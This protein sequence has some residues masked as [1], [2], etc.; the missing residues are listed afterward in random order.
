[1]AYATLLLLGVLDAAGYSVIAPVVPAIGRANEAGPGVLGP[2]VATF[3]LGMAAGFVVASRYLQRHGAYAV[4]AGSLG[5]MALGSLGFVAGHGLVLY[6]GARLLMG[7]GSGGLWIGTVFAILERWPGEEYRRMSGLLAV[8]SLG[9]IAGPAFGVLGGIRGPFGLYLALVGV[10]AP[11]LLMLERPRERARFESDRSVLRFPGFLLACAAVLLVAL[12]MGT[13]DGPLPVHF[14]TELSQTQISGLYVATSIV[15]GLSA[16]LGSRFPPAPLVAVA[17]ALMVAGISLAGVGTSVAVWMVAAAVL[18]L[19]LG[20]GEAGATGVFLETIGTERIVLAMVVW[21]QV[22]ALGY[23]A[24]PAAAGAVA[25]VAGFGAI[26][27]VP[28]AASLLVLAAF[29]RMARAPAS[30]V[31]RGGT[32]AA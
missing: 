17:T 32:E 8:Y 2:L 23:L 11:L 6:F 10:C 12:S 30:R 20:I 13:F 18:G 28:L 5:T 16:W 25:E 1:M 14:A 9:G 26:G 7:L 29:V 4:L 19:G 3:A 27:L 24:G 22:W 31:V 15:V 21:S